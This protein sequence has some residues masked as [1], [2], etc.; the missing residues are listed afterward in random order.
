MET[1]ITD[2]GK[3]AIT[4]RKDYKNE[5]TYEWLDVVTHDGASYM[6]IAEDGCTGIVPTNT[7]YW[8]LLAKGGDTGE[9]GDKGDPGDKGDTGDTGAK[10]DKGEQGIKGEK[11]DKGDKGDK[12]IKG[13]DYFTEEE[14]T[15]F[16]NAVVAESKEEIE[17]TKNGAI[18]DINTAKD[19]AIADYDEHV[20]DLT[21]RVDILEK[22]TGHIYGIKRKITDNTAS[23]WE[24]IGD[25]VGLVANARK[26]TTEA[27]QNDFS[28]RYPWN[29]IK[30][31]N[32]DANGNVTTFIGE[33]RIR[34]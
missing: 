27:V 32:I 16:K 28:A 15:E 2:I 1:E 8:Q 5:Q 26:A 11:G 24:R 29:E 17:T 7:D 19:T 20:K 23:T 10:G 4:P 33:P 18:E 12:P 13:T 21:E 34:I 22:R 14:K 3:V 25:S 30:T 6:C 31:C 9:K